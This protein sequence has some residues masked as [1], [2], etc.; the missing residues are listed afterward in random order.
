MRPVRTFAA[1]LI[2]TILVCCA[3]EDAAPRS[4]G[5]DL[6]GHYVSTTPTTSGT[7]ELEPD[8]TFRLLLPTGQTGTESAPFAG[9]GTWRLHVDEVLEGPVQVAVLSFGDWDGALQE[10]PTEVPLFRFDEQLVIGGPC[11]TWMFRGEN[12]RN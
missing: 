3:S 9:R 7:L 6:P 8:G 2:T 1:G 11:V 4:P 5:R 10:P 12:P